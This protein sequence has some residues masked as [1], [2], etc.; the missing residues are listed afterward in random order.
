MRNLLEH[1]P[2]SLLIVLFIVCGSLPVLLPA[3]L[4]I[5]LALIP[6]GCAV[7]FAVWAVVIAVV[8]WVAPPKSS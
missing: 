3:N 1:W 5:K 8:C 6:V 2:E 4:W 7:G